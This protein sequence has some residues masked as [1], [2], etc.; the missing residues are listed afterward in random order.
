VPPSHERPRLDEEL[1][2]ASAAG[3]V[4][5][6]LEAEQEA[7]LPEGVLLAVS[8]RET[9]CRDVV[10]E[11]GHR[12]GAF[13]I[14]DRYHAGWLAPRLEAAAGGTPPLAEAARYAAGLI[15]ANLDFGQAN[16]VREAELLKFALSA[17]G[18]A[19][20]PA[21]EG[22]RHGDSDL[23][24]PGHDYGADVLRRLAAI[25]LWLASHGGTSAWPLL[26]PG[27]RGDSVIELKRLLREWYASRG[28]RPPRR[29]RGPVYSMGAVEAVREFQEAMGLTA[30]GVVGP[31]TWRLLSGTA[32]SGDLPCT[33][34][35]A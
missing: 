27:D 29:M 26:E 21:L 24:T 16:G 31:E 34:A 17:Y 22:Y 8:S 5:A 11:D 3:I 18:V 13:G 1:L 7:H 4:R 2:A 6:A 35:C 10:S 25:R 12:H 30:D 23:E 9:G 20:S 19:L 32:D 14:D 33:A 15:S 28:A